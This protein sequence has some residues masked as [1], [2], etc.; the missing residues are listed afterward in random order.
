VLARLQA[1]AISNAEQTGLG[2]VARHLLNLVGCGYQCAG[3]LAGLP[4][5]VVGQFRLKCPDL[6]EQLQF[7][8][9]VV[10]VVANHDA[11]DRPVLLLHVA[12]VV[13]PWPVVWYRKFQAMRSEAF[14]AAAAEVLHITESRIQPPLL[15]LG[16]DDLRLVVV[17]PQPDLVHPVPDRGRSDDLGTAGRWPGIVSL[18]LQQFL[19]CRKKVVGQLPQVR[20]QLRAR[21]HAHI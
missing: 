2:I 16:L 1:A 15:V 17:Q 18:R 20:H 4:A 13:Q 11:H 19:E 8:S 5:E 21:N 9:G 14:S 7:C 12:A 6:V 3:Q 10:A